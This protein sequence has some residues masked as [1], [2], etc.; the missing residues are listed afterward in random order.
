MQQPSLSQSPFHAHSNT[1]TSKTNIAIIGVCEHR[2]HCIIG[3]NPNE[4]IQSQDILVDIEVEFDITQAA[5]S[6]SVNDT[7]SYVDLRDLST[8]LA[9]TRQYQ[10]LETFCVEFVNRVEKD[11]GPKGALSCFIQIKKPQVMS[12]TKYPYVSLRRSFK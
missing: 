3:V 11:F 8:E 10:L 6:D 7:L 1:S 12:T 5:L 2:I 9:T 4:R